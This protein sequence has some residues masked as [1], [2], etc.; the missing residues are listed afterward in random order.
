[1]SACSLAGIIAM[2]A[3]EQLNILMIKLDELVNASEGEFK[4]THRKLTGILQHYL[5]ILRYRGKFL[6]LYLDI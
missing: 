4:A 2:H 5:R 1:M 3:C 6:T